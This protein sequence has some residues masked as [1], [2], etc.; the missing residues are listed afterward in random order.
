MLT[1]AIRAIVQPSTQ[2]RAEKARIV[3]KPGESFNPCRRSADGALPF[4][5]R[6]RAA[7]LIPGQPSIGAPDGPREAP[8]GPRRRVPSPLPLLVAGVGAQHAHDAVASY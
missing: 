8:P 2:S 6:R 7:D 5:A 3:V 4:L 1:P